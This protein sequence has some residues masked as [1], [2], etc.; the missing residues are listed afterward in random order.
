MNIILESGVFEGWTK[1]DKHIFNIQDDLKTLPPRDFGSYVDKNYR[2]VER[3]GTGKE[4]EF[5]RK[6]G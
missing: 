3:R 2:G 1:L 5:C 4:G 6:S